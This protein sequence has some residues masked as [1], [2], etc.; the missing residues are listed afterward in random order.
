MGYVTSFYGFMYGMLYDMFHGGLLAFFAGCFL[1]VIILL[2][3][4]LLI[5]VVF[6][7]VDSW[8]LTKK[9]KRGY[10]TWRKYTPGYWTPETSMIG[11]D[12]VTTIVPAVYTPQL[13]SVGVRVGDDYATFKVD[14]HYYDQAHEHQMVTV[15]YVA[16]RMNNLLYI[17]SLS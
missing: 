9:V 11:D 12:G 4:G 10:I 17:E 1:A 6:H 5:W 16:N 3:H 13:W 14:Q 2:V 15:H 7:A 8:L